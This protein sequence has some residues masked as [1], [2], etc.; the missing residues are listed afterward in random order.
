VKEMKEKGVNESRD[1]GEK[2]E[3]LEE[4][5]NELE[6]KMEAGQGGSNDTSGQK[7]ALASI[8]SESDSLTVEEVDGR[9]VVKTS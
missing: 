6:E 2:V 5:I 7:Q 9:K 8:A 3:E 4:R 1:A